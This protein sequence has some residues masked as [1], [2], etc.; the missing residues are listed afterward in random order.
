MA[1]D[2]I[3]KCLICDRSRTEDNFFTFPYEDNPKSPPIC[4]ETDCLQLAYNAG[5]F[6]PRYMR[7][8]ETMWNENPY[9]HSENPLHIVFVAINQKVMPRDSDS[10]YP[11][12]GR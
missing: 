9:L 8:V 3:H 4:Q 5:L 6:N 11:P 7:D 12:Y 10:P 2:D 1:D